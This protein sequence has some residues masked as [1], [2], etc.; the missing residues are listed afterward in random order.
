MSSGRGTL[1]VGVDGS[2]GALAALRWAVAQARPMYADVVAVHVWQPSAR[3]RAPY[4]PVDGLASPSDDRRRAHRILDDTVARVL[5][6]EPGARLRPLLTEGPTV[7]V[8]VAHSDRAQL[9]VLGRRSSE[10]PA[11]P[12]LGAVARACIRRARCP[13]VT[14]PEAE[15]DAP[16]PT[17]PALLVPH[18]TAAEG[19]PS[20]TLLNRRADDPCETATGAERPSR[21][22]GHR[23]P[24]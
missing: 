15:A 21:N 2:R 22:R 19:A 3:Y 9:L 20:R 13:V 4:A 24:F 14:V 12:A 10:D 23:R 6:W 8:L 1:I 17:A 18:R 11:L 7:P 16:R 5:A